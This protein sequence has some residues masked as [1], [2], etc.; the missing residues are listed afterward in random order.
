MWSEL[1]R[2]RQDRTPI[3]LFGSEPFSSLLRVSN[4]KEF[5]YDWVWDKKIP[6]NPFLAKYQPLKITENL[7]VFGKKSPNYY[8]IMI[9]R[10]KPLRYKDNYGGGEAFIKKGTGNKEY[11]LEYKNPKNIITISNA[12]RKGIQHPTQK[13]LKLMEYLITTYTQEGDLVL[14]FTCGSGTTLL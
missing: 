12:N 9:K 1:K 13:P 6:G 2:I 8:P 10:E 11:T 4:L 5:R 14:D 7:I 3:V